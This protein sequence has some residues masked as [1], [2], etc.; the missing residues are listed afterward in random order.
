MSGAAKSTPLKEWD[1]RRVS[2]SLRRTRNR[3]R[4]TSRFPR[5]FPAGVSKGQHVIEIFPDFAVLHFRS[6]I[7]WCLCCRKFARFPTVRTELSA[8]RG[9]LFHDFCRAYYRCYKTRSLLPR[10]Y[11]SRARFL[12]QTVSLLGA[13]S[14]TPQNRLPRIAVSALLDKSFARC[15][16]RDMHT[17]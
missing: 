2:I 5:R 11:L 7:T 13:L 12:Y 15:T 6:P 17:S 4:I 16:G 3:N 1:S 14:Y 9:P 10:L 8:L